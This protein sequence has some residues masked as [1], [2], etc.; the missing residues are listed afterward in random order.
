MADFGYDISDYNAIDSV[1]GTMD[2]FVSLQK[3]LKSL[4]K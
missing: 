4:G 1:Y 3:K 2:D